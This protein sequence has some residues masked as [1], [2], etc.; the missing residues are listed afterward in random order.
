MMSLK[1]DN[2][3]FYWTVVTEK[4]VNSVF[5]RVSDLCAGILNDKSVFSPVIGIFEK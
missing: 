2:F 3:R 1:F 4:R 5:A